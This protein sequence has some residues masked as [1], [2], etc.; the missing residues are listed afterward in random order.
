MFID[1]VEVK[2]L[3]FVPFPG[4]L[5]RYAEFVES[6]VD[7]QVDKILV[8]LCDDGCV[9]IRYVKQNQKFERIRRITG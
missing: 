3:N 9:D 6:N 5:E 7:G 2:A 4:E 1:G 8:E